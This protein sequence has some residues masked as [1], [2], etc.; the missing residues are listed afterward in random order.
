MEP[1][2]GDP[3]IWIASC[4]ETGY[5]TSGLGYA[6]AK[7]NMLEVLRTETLY[8]QENGRKL[9]TKSPIPAAL[10]KKWETVTRDNPPQTVLL[11]PEESHKRPAGRVTHQESVTVARAVR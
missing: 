3:N 6:E 8:A 4:L 9:R 5:V 2:E 10:E 7:E 1:R 11:F